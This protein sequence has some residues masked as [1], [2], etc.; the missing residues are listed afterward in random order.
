MF[1]G[2]LSWSQPS[3]FCQTLLSNGANGWDWGWYNGWKYMYDNDFAF[4][5]HLIGTQRINN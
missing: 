1:R 2:N 5:Y 4:W 3:K